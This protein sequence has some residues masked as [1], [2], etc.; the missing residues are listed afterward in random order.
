MLITS[1]KYCIL[2]FVLICSIVLATICS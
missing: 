1:T 2:I